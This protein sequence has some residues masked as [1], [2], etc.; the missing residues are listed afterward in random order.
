MFV[1]CC[2]ITA[3]GKRC[4]R[5]VKRGNKCGPHLKSE[6]GLRIAP[7]RLHNGGWGLFTTIDRCKGDRIACYT[8]K[9]VILDGRSSSGSSYGG[10]YVL[11]LSR[12]HFIDAAL[13][14]SCAARFSNTARSWNIAHKECRGNNAHFTLDRRGQGTAWITATRTI[15]AGEEVL[16]AYG[17]TFCISPQGATST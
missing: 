7:S 15:R 17:R 4:T 13:P 12:T 3:E 14:T 2:S 16:T 9:R 11:Q 5:Q 10:E 6:D 8:G 1:Q